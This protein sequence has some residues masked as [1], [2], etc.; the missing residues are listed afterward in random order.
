M[1][2]LLTFCRVALTA[3]GSKCL[4]QCTSVITRNNILS[5]AGRSDVDNQLIIVGLDNFYKLMEVLGLT[6]SSHLTK[7]MSLAE[8]QTSSRHCLL[9]ARLSPKEVLSAGSKHFETQSTYS[10]LNFD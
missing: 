6:D 4:S 8:N 7:C 3:L 2:F 1:K 9:A 5:P 10:S